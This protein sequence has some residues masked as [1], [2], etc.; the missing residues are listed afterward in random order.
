MRPFPALDFVLRGEPELTLRE[1]LDTLRGQ[2][3]DRPAGGE[4]A[5]GDERRH[6][7]QGTG[8]SGR[9]PTPDA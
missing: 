8:V 4:D 5:G 1:L 7:S 6:R 2:G 9:E 3:A